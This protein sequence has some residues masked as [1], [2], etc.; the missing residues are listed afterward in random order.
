[1]QLIQFEEQ[2]Q[3]QEDSEIDIYQDLSGQGNQLGAINPS[4]TQSRLSDTNKVHS[5]IMYHTREAAEKPLP[6]TT[7]H[8]RKV[9]DYNPNGQNSNY[10]FS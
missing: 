5:G 1:M 7:K 4:H 3:S 6:K 2:E 9:E 10:A 8:G